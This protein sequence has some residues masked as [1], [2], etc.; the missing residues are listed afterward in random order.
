LNFSEQKIEGLNGKFEKLTLLH[1]RANR[2][3]KAVQNGEL[4]LNNAR[5]W[6]AWMRILP[7]VRR[8]TSQ[9]KQH[10]THN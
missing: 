9:Y 5:V 3:P 4:I 2:E 1:E 6:F 10:E 8:E 7:F